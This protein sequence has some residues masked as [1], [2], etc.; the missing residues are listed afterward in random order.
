MS[1][2]LKEAIELV[3]K[4]KNISKIA[5]SIGCSRKKVQNVIKHYQKNRSFANTRRSRPRKTTKRKDTLNIRQA[6]N[7]P[8]ATSTQIRATMQHDYGVNLAS[9]TIRQQILDNNL[10]GCQSLKK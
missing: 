9:R 6:L 2:E 3:A 8:F 10:R 5:R 7:D 1:A 4:E